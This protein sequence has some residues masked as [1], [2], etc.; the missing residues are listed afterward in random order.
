MNRMKSILSLTA[1]S[2]L[3]VI[4]TE[5]KAF[6]QQDPMYTMY[7]WN[8]LT[9]NPGYAGS[10]DRLSLT[11]LSRHQWTGLKGA[12]STQSLVAST[13]LKDQHL[14]I[15]LSLNHDKVGPIMN[16]SVYGDFAYRMHLNRQTRLAFGLK[17]GLNFLQGNFTGLENTDPTDP[18]FQQN[19]PN[20]VSPNFGFG[21]Y[22]Y[23]LKGYV[24]VAAPKLLEDE[25]VVG[26]DDPGLAGFFDEQ[27]HYFFIAGYVFD[28]NDDL[29]YRP[30]IM[31]KAVKGAPVS[32]DV[33]NMFLFVEKFWAG[34]AYRHNS[35]ISGVLSYQVTDQLRAGYAY[36][37]T[38]SGLQ[39]YQGGSHEIM[40]TYDLK[41]IKHMVLSPRYF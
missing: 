39:G 12:P 2:L 38:T 30:S 28:L 18:N 27:R 4:G 23:S 21:L 29:K 24:G 9:V 34:L 20:K 19:A 14:G 1:F 8:T 35:S 22:L 7:M 26:S 40:L 16:T 33:T 13:P 31:V 37:F 17:A 3:I 15:G 32:I 25:L 11:A 6:G 41:F 5:Q 36:D 10:A